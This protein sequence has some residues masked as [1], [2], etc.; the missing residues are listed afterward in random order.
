MDQY[1]GVSFTTVSVYT[2]PS[3]AAFAAIYEDA[4]GTLRKDNPFI[5]FGNYSFYAATGQYVL[6][7]DFRQTLGQTPAV[8]YANLPGTP[9]VG[10]QRIITDSSVTAWGAVAADGGS[11]TV[12]VWYNG[13][14]WTVLGK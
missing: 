9:V 4:G 14:D 2:D 8:V 13:T 1:T 5:S 6:Q 7:G 11:D 3:L 12:L 10:M